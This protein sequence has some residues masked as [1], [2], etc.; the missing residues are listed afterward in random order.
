MPAFDLSGRVAVVSGAGNAGGIGFACAALLGAMGS[1]VAIGGTSKRIHDRAE[2]LQADGVEVVA[3]V[4]D[5]T[6]AAAA[7]E[8]VSAART[9][10]GRLD[11][12]VN[13]AGMVS[14]AEP[15]FESGGVEELSEETWHASLRRNL[16]TAFLLTR[17]SVPHLRAGGW[18]RVVMVSSVTGPVMAMRN[19]VA[20]ASA[21]AGLVGMCRALAVDLA[22]AG[23]TVNAVAPGWI[24]T[25]SQTAGEREQGFATP[26]RRSGTAA[27]VAAAVGWFCS[28]GASYVTGQLLCVD[29]GNSVAEQRSA[30]IAG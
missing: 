3:V 25:P 19:D 4:G 29:G 17:A 1:A 22:D 9:S 14:L 6:S 21:K 13:N 30:N 5:L 10:W 15:D 24:G 8:L 2:E 18:G 28:P 26:L 20:Y 27:E 12:V 11:A 23:V 7:Q 16:D